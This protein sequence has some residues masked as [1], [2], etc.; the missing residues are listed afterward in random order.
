MSRTEFRE[1]VSK[2]VY[3]CATPEQYEEWRKAARLHG[4]PLDSW[5]CTDCTPVYQLEM[6]K[7]GWCVRPEIRFKK[8]AGEGIEGYLPT[9][10]KDRT[11]E[12]F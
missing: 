8:S 10:H 3:L 4:P 2:I 1:K 12:L 6:K 9:K 7:K 11:G 5:F